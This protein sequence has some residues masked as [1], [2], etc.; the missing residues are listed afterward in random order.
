MTIASARV[1]PAFTASQGALF[2]A[3]NA[4]TS[5]TSAS[6]SELVTTA[7]WNHFS[8]IVY[9]IPVERVR[10]LVP[11]GFDV[12][13]I[14]MT[15]AGTGAIK[16]CALISVVSFLDNGS[17]FVIGNHHPFEQTV[18]RLHVRHN[19]EQGFWVLGISAGS[20][21]AVS[22]RR[23]WSMPWHLSAMELQVA[24]NSQ[25]ASYQ[26]Y[27]LRASSQMTNSLIEI[28]D[29]GIPLAG[30]VYGLLPRQTSAWFLRRDETI[31]EYRVRH[32]APQFTTGRLKEARFDL[33]E[34]A[35]L[36]TREEMLR[37]VLV[38]LQH[39]INAEIHNPVSEKPASDYALQAAC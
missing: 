23:L 12:E 7:E 21:T 27:R 3:K 4:R 38:T 6:L 33:L 11:E 17:G 22:A 8:A 34:R 15:E 25:E 28:Q 32:S 36:L 20:L 2:P 9:A 35:G 29:T 19:G 14:S 26:N 5:Q 24:R 16:T 10:S 39:A 37:P 13:E 30:D 1:T 31:G 18:Y